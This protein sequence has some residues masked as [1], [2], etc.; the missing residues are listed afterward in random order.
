MQERERPILTR[1]ITFEDAPH[2]R[3]SL[4]AKPVGPQARI[5]PIYRTGG[6]VTFSA[7]RPAADEVRLDEGLSGGSPAAG[8]GRVPQVSHGVGFWFVAVAFTVLMAFGT[9]PT[10]LWPLYEARD[11]FGDT[12]VTVAYA[13]LVIGTSFGFSVLGHLSDRF[14]RRRVVLPAL[15]VGTLAAVLLALW[16]SLVGLL[17]GRF[18]NG[19][20]IGLMASTA[21]TYLHD[22]YRRQHPDHP[23][24]TLPGVVAAMANLGGLALGPL[25]AGVIAQWLPHPLITTQLGFAALMG[26]C[27]L[28]TA[29]TPETVDRTRQAAARPSRFALKPGTG[30]LFGSAAVTGFFA[31]ALLGLVSSLGAIMLNTNLG[32]ASHFVAGLTSFV[33]FAASAIAQI[34]LGK[35]S[36]RVMMFVGAILFPVGLALVSASFYHPALW[37]FLLAVA[38]AG[39]G[40][41]VLFKGGVATAVATAAERSQAGVLALYFVV[42]YIG[43][44]VPAILFSV[45]ITHVRIGPA[46]I[47]FAAILSVGA[48]LSV[49]AGRIAQAPHTTAKHRGDSSRL[50]M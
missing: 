42:G 24:A 15:I 21:T 30:A 40:A 3:D 10:P 35:L 20:A 9:G 7:A 39:A 16:P 12:T 23:G 48:V 17:V 29:A 31:F 34:F 46:M 14:G 11:G 27:L 22:L 45:V 33:M 50:R 37:L 41:G 13:V 32:I 19:L 49:V 28:M 38:I 26:I 25:A 6:H 47:G 36:P 2:E 5:M 1:A 8:G 44:G 43:M 4:D 18:L